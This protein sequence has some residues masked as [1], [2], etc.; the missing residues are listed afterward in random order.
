MEPDC[1]GF[2]PEK[3]AVSSIGLGKV[4]CDFAARMELLHIGVRLP[5]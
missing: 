4:L 1:A 5:L 2:D 3:K